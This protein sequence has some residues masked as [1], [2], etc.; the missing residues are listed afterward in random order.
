MNYKQI[1]KIIE[2]TIDKLT[3]EYKQVDHNGDML[4][5]EGI[6]FYIDSRFTNSP[7]ITSTIKNNTKIP[8][9]NKLYENIVNYL[10]TFDATLKISILKILAEM[11][12]IVRLYRDYIICDSTYLIYNENENTLEDASLISLIASHN[13][14]FHLSDPEVFNQLSNY[15][16]TNR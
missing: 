9:D 3:K 2:Q 12:H 6:H 1:N 4:K 5:I 13:T 15:I 16:K 7:Q 8:I 11:G 10:S 14:K